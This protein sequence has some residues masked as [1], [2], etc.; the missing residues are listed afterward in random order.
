MNTQTTI[1]QLGGYGRLTAM[2]GARNFIDH[3]NALSF[4]F[5]GSRKANYVKIE[6]DPSDTYNVTF[7]K[8]RKYELTKERTFEGVHATMLRRLFEQ[9]TGLYLTL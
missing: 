6:L 3:G 1:N 7:G 8:I 2:T 9:V 4:K 5:K